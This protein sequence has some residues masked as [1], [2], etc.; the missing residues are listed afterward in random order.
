MKGDSMTSTEKLAE[1]LEKFAYDQY[2]SEDGYCGQEVEWELLARHIEKLLLERA[3]EE[4]K[5]AYTCHPTLSLKANLKIRL[6]DLTTQLQKL[7]HVEIKPNPC[8]KCQKPM[9]LV[10]T[11]D[12]NTAYWKCGCG[13]VCEKGG[14]R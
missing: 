9:E 6:F 11:N 10:E 4:L 8:P 3:I 13:C 5:S 1:E 7:D 2:D 12:I 14:D